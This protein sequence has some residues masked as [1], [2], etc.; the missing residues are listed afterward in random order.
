[1]DTLAEPKPACPHSKTYHRLLSQGSLGLRAE[2]DPSAGRASGPVPLP[3]PS[4][5]DQ[6]SS[7]ATE[8]QMGLGSPNSTVAGPG[9]R[10][11]HNMLPFL[12]TLIFMP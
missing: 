3:G 8:P 2:T 5:P 9:S 7:F 4:A 6:Q 11:P 1:M 12:Q 10:C